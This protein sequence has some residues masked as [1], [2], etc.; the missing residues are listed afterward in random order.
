MDIKHQK[1][2]MLW[3]PRFRESSDCIHFFKWF[4]R[5]EKE[6]GFKAGIV[7]PEVGVPTTVEQVGIINKGKDQDT[8][9]AKEFIDWFGSAEVQG[10]WA[11]QFGSLPVNTKA[12][13]KLQ[14]ESNQLV[15]IQRFKKW[16]IPSFLNIL[17]IG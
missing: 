11:E 7:S 17:T 10:A 16:T 13:K 5:L 8:A 4:T 14:T 3:Q 9:V 6:F 15:K 1:E 2:K 12:L